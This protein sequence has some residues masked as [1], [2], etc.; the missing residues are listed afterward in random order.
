MVAQEADKKSSGEKQR[1]VGL[2]LKKTRGLEGRVELFRGFGLCYFHVIRPM[3]WE[4]QELN[5]K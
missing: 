4:G 1:I 2:R 5:P 3:G